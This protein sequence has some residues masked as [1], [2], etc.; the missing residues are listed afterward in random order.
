MKVPAAAEE[1]LTVEDPSIQEQEYEQEQDLGSPVGIAAKGGMA[2]AA[3][4][5]AG[6]DCRAAYTQGSVTATL[7]PGEHPVST[8]RGE[9]GTAQMEKALVRMS[10]SLRER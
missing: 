6:A 2:V 4:A 7:M 10:R 3:Y 5:Y 8:E 9:A 1:V